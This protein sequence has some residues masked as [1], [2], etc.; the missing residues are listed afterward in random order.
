VP[1]IEVRELVVRYGELT[2]VDS[3]SFEVGRGEV[4]GLLGPNGAGKTSTVEV[5]EGYRRATSGEVRVLGLDPHR[6]HAALTESMGVMLQGGG[7][8][9]MMGAREALRLFA[10]YYRSPRDPDELLELVG[11]TAVARTASKR[12]SGGERQRLALALA[13][14]GRP[15]VA[16]LDEPTAGIDP[17][18]R[19]L[20]REVIRSLRDAGTS[21]LLT[22]HELPEAEHLADRV[23]I[24]D[25]GR[26][27]ATGTPAELTSGAESIRFSAAPGIDAPALG[28]V[29]GHPVRETTRGEYEVAAPPAPATIASLT[30][31]LAEHD[32]PLGDLRAGRHRLEDV[33]MRLTAEDGATDPDAGRR[34]PKGRR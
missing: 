31:W 15:E 11:L 34:R 29:L 32:V 27:V 16:F 19:V 20:V 12:L 25:H 5:L 9:P 23:V 14:V 26:A 28:R 4:V 17:A 18:G 2:A 10:A 6:Q 13:V 24:I 21:V 1:S 22:T 8:Y 30:A 7:I 3:L 33:F